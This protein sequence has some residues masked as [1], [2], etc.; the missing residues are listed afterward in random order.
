LHTI[1]T[2]LAIV[3]AALLAARAL[4]WLAA[5][6][7]MTLS[8]YTVHVFA[9]ATKAGLDDRPTL[10]LIHVVIALGLGLIWTAL[11]ARGPLEQLLAK[12]SALARAAGLI[13][14]RAS[15]SPS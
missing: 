11:F 14:T 1:G 4:G 15:R 10:L 6:G 2:S 8:L 9:L 5:A 7:A 3:G 13:S 12:T